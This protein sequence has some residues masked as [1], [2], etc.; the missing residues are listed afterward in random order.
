MQQKKPYKKSPQVLCRAKE[1]LLLPQN[2]NP[3]P[4]SVPQKKP[5]ISLCRQK[6]TPISL[7]RKRKPPAPTPSA[8]LRKSKENLRRKLPG[9]EAKA[10]KTSG[11]TLLA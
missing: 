2:M 4:S 11:E 6:K 8:V 10:K 1:N 3:A 9:T 5:P 7:C